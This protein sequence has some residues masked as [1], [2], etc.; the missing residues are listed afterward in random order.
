MSLKNDGN[1]ISELISIES[2][3]KAKAYM[4]KARGGCVAAFLQLRAAGG[5]G[6]ICIFSAYSKI[7]RFQRDNEL[8]IFDPVPLVTAALTRGDTGK[9]VCFIISYVR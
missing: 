4:C 9:N 7:A 2:F 6:N 1:T 5:W 3:Q 8:T